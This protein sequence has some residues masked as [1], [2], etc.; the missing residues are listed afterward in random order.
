MAYTVAE[1][2]F[3]TADAEELYA[4]SSWAMAICAPR[5]ERAAAWTALRERIH[6]LDAIGLH[7]AIAGHQAAP[8]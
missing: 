8:A 2:T 5:P 3:K 7:E 1:T 6:A 4:V